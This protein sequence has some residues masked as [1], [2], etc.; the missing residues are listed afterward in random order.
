MASTYWTEQLGNKIVVCAGEGYELAT[1]WFKK[2]GESESPLSKMEA[3]GHAKRFVD[4]LNE[5]HPITEEMAKVFGDSDE[6][7]EKC[8][9]VNEMMND[10]SKDDLKDLARK[11]ALLQM[12]SSIGE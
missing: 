8:K 3:E 6:S 10:K 7:I 5:E 11:M 9:E 12:M 2:E 4:W 1:F